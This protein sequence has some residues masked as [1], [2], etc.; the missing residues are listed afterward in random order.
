MSVAEA[1]AGSDARTALLTALAALSRDFNGVKADI[2]RR[3]ELLKQALDAFSR[4]ADADPEFRSAGRLAPENELEESVRQVRKLLAARI[5]VWREKV[6]RYDRRT[7]FRQDF[8]DSLLVYVFGKVKAGKSSLGNYVAYGRG[9][10]SDAEVAAYRAAGTAPEFF[11]SDE[12]GKSGIELVCEALLREGRFAVDALEATSAIQGFRFPGLTW[13]DSPG[14]HSV[15]QENGELASKYVDAADLV[16][17][18]TSS[19]QPGRRSDLV[20]IAGLLQ[21]RKSVLVVITRCDRIDEDEDEDGNIVR[22]R[23]MKSDKDRQDQ[24]AYVQGELDAI[25]AQQGSALADAKVM[26][27]SVS[28]AEEHEHDPAE[29]ARSGMPGLLDRLAVLTRSQGVEFKKTVPLNNL[30]SFVDEVL[31][32]S[33]SLDALAADVGTLHTKIAD[34]RAQL[35][36]MRKQVTAYIRRDLEPEIR[37]AIERLGAAPTKAA[38]AEACRTVTEEVTRRHLVE[39]MAE[40]FQDVDEAVGAAARLEEFGDLPEFEEIRQE[41]AVSNEARTR[42][43]GKTV[44]RLVGLAAKLIPGAGLIVAAVSSEIASWLGETLGGAMATQESIL[45]TTG[46][47]L[48]Q[49]AMAA[50]DAANDSAEKAVAQAIQRL[51]QDILHPVERHAG[52][53]LAAK[54][55]LASTLEKE[56]RP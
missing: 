45:I 49:I 48:Q 43:V 19:A 30:R 32:G 21:R 11:V 14:I 5:A 47:N 35:A 26:T 7:K 27:V 41:I 23:V 52:T 55:R 3:E 25:C 38:V 44:G 8:G 36:R 16:L 4:V 24:V 34:Q 28:F 1:V 56:V 39:A 15:T 40:I 6:E 17:Y 42:A 37:S 33:M 29:L 9:K 31:T 20:E 18:P 10:P 22:C 12:S 2:S 13:V 46:N 50:I 51:D 54:D 53:I